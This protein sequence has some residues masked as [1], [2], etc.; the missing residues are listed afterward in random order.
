M[1]GCLASCIIFRNKQCETV[2]ASLLA[3]IHKDR[4]CVSVSKIKGKHKKGGERYS[5][6]PVTEVSQRDCALG[7]HVITTDPIS[8]NKGDKQ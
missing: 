4:V 8:S 7:K 2:L 1:N 3:Y 6:L 5:P